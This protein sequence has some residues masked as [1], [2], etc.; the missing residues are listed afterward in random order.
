[1]ACHRCFSYH[2]EIIIFFLFQ[3]PRKGPHSQM[4]DPV[5]SDLCSQPFPGRVLDAPPVRVGVGSLPSEVY[6]IRSSLVIVQIH[7]PLQIPFP[8]VRHSCGLRL[9]PPFSPQTYYKPSFFPLPPS[10]FLG[11]HH[12]GWSHLL[13]PKGTFDCDLAVST[14]CVLVLLPYPLVQA[15]LFSSLSPSW[16]RV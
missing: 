13:L 8:I 4:D 6:T 15:S 14:T 5:T 1:M 16:L 10:S 9:W 11:Y 7:A 2:F 12:S 3:L